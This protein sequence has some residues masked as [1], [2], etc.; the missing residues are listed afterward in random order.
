M[1][2]ERKPGSEH[3]DV[4]RDE[5]T[6][7]P[8]PVCGMSVGPGGAFREIHGGRE[9]VFCS[10]SCMERFREDPERYLAGAGREVLPAT[11]TGGAAGQYTCPMH[12]EVVQRGP[13]ACPICG[14]A[15][16]PMQPSAQEEANHELIDMKRRFWICAAL[17]IPLVAIAMDEMI[18]GHPSRRLAS[19]AALM[20][21]QLFLAA[22]VVLWGAW[23]FFVRAW[24][25][26]LTRNLNMFTLIG[27]GVGTAY[28][29]SLVA[30]LF[31]RWFPA[32]F[33]G[34]GGEAGVYFEASAV[35][36]TLVWLGQVLEL[37]ARS[38][39]GEAIRALLGLAPKTA[40]KIAAD[41]TEADVSL[42]EVVP[43]DH[44][45]VRPGEKVPVDGEIL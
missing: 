31:P 12:P 27:I 11:E 35:I 37:G 32:S 33:R 44:L 1:N 25:S 40:R 20:I 8:D 2:D 17:T 34:P 5:P 23:P 41:G 30:A 15:L 28:G 26:L 36:V 6:S 3:G 42:D 13:G 14:M 29:Y 7:S 22:P 19:P 9:F 16:E 18:P 43:G 38:R 10:T 4:R 24:N 21:I 45:R 39:T